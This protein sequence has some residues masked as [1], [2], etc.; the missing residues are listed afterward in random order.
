MLMYISLKCQ[1]VCLRFQYVK[2]DNLES[3]G[4]YGFAGLR[5]KE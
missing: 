3:H 5:L 4:V 2:Y 1:P